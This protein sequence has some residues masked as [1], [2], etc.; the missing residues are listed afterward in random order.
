M[1]YAWEKQRKNSNAIFISYVQYL[2]WFLLSFWC[3]V[4][5]WKCGAWHDMLYQFHILLM[6]LRIIDTV[7]NHVW[8]S[9]L[10]HK[11]ARDRWITMIYNGANHK[12]I[13]I[14][15]I[16]TDITRLHVDLLA[17]SIKSIDMFDFRFQLSA[18]F[19]C[20]HCLWHTSNNPNLRE[21][22]NSDNRADRFHWFGRKTGGI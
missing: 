5:W 9:K 7:R 10:N 11:F 6:V 13:Y 16:F 15:F 2:G 4:T 18:Y 8:N 14:H 20:E 3:D 12:K 17:F 21:C 19:D 22:E 1:T